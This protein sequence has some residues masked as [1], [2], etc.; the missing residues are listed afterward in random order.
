MSNEIE[1]KGREAAVKVFLSG[2]L[3]VL[4]STEIASYY[5]DF[6]KHLGLNPMTQ[7]FSIIS[8][9]NVKKLYAN[10]SAS[11]QLRKIN[12]ISIIETDRKVENGFIFYEVKGRDG[13]G[14]I[15][16][17]LAVVPLPTSGNDNI[18]NAFMKAETKAK[19]RLTLS[20]SGLGM[21]DETEASTIKGATLEPVVLNDDIN[22]QVKDANKKLD[23]VLHEEPI[24]HFKEDEATDMYNELECRLDY[25]RSVAENESI[26][27]LE[28]NKAIN[29][30]MLNNEVPDKILNK[31]ELGNSKYLEGTELVFVS[32]E[33]FKK[34]YLEGVK[35]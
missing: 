4:N 8:K 20:L 26:F 24:Q 28:M 3:S 10:K 16:T 22:S 11:E 19:R 14:R 12:S 27:S 15:D 29:D 30:S 6:C 25:L 23:D 5:N 21:I 2:D 18:A 34:L 33:E 9:G 1:T 7:P 35:K 31:I 32:Y 17:G 13:D